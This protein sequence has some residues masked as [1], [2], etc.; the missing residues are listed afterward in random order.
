M[1]TTVLN[2][3]T[4][5]A[6][7]PSCTE[8]ARVG[9]YVR[10]RKKKYPPTRMYCSLIRLM[11]ATCPHCESKPLR[12]KVLRANSPSVATV[13]VGLSLGIVMIQRSVLADRRNYR[14]GVANAFWA[15]AWTGRSQSNSEDIVSTKKPQHR[16]IHTLPTHR[17][18]SSGGVLLD[19][20]NDAVLVK[21]VAAFARH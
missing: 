16:E 8:S 19:P 6:V 14:W 7:I 4:R 15:W 20:L 21:V 1:I 11:P 10:L 3:T 9:V 18:L 5:S 2:F 17:T 12:I 13:G